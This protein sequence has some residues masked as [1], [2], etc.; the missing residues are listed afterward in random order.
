MKEEISGNVVKV[1]R[2]NDR[3]RAIVLTLGKEVM[4][5]IC[6]YGPQSGRPDTEK[7]RFYD[8]MMSE[9][10]LGSSSVIIVSLGDFNGYVGKCDEGFEG[11]D[12]GN[13]NGKSKAEGRS[14][15]EFC[16]EKEL[17][18]ANIWFYKADMRKIIYSANGCETEIDFVLVEKNT[19][20]AKL[21]LENIVTDTSVKNGEHPTMP[22][23][24]YLSIVHRLLLQREND[25]LK[26]QSHY[27]YSPVM[28]KPLQ[29]RWGISYQITL[30]LPSTFSTA[31]HGK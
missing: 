8:E 28:G 18:Q 10:E 12:G 30:G 26:L 4:R 22:W 1:R 5:I 25:N 16:G 20:M 15:M 29:L 6:A 11:V 7:V 21:H 19:E 13:S 23:Q 2:K 9:W 14:L 17:C 31:K 3:V 27:I 24:Y